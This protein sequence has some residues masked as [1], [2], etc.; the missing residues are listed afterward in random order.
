MAHRFILR[1]SDNSEQ[2][3]LLAGAEMLVGTARDCQIRL[4]YPSVAPYH[5]RV[6]QSA[7]GLALDAL[8][9][10]S[11]VLVNGYLTPVG[12]PVTLTDGSVVQFGDVPLLFR[13]D[14]QPLAQIG[15][16][17]YFAVVHASQALAVT[18]P[19]VVGRDPACDVVISSTQVS[20]RHAQLTPAGGGVFVLED[21]GSTNGTFLNGRRVTRP[22]QVSAGQMIQVALCKLYFDGATLQRFDEDGMVR[23]DAQGITRMIAGG[24]V[25][26]HDITLTVQ[27]RE[28]VAVVGASGAGKSTLLYA[29]S[30]IHPA[31][32]GRVFFNGIDYYRYINLFRASLGYVPQDDIIHRELT[33]EGALRYAA[34]LRMPPDVTA[35]EIEQRI[36]RVLTSLHLTERRSLRVSALSGGQ[37]KRVN[38]GVE[39]MTTPSL[40]FLDEPTS[41]LDPGLEKMMMGELKALAADG[42]TV[43]VVTHAT[44]SIMFCDLVIFMAAG[45]RVAFFGPPQEA[46]E[47]FG[48]D[49]FADIYQAVDQTET[50]EY[51]EAKYKRSVYCDKHVRHRGQALAAVLKQSKEADDQALG[52][53][54]ASKPRVSGWRQLFT[55]TAR[56]CQVMKGDLFNLFYLAMQAPI[57]ALLMVGIFYYK[58]CFEPGSEHVFLGQTVL[59]MLTMSAI[60]FGCGNAAQEICKELPIYRRE[61]MISLKLWP[62]V[63]SKFIVLGLLGA[64]QTIAM[65]AILQWRIFH[66]DLPTTIHMWGFLMMLSLVGCAIGL[67]ISAAASTPDQA[68]TWVPMVLLPQMMLAGIMIPIEKATRAMEIMSHFVAIKWAF[69]GIGR[70]SGL[71]DMAGPPIEGLADKLPP[72][73]EVPTT[74]AA[75]CAELFSRYELSTCWLVLAAFLVAHILIVMILVKLKDRVD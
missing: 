45:G 38:I 71:A 47:H 36:D 3:F 14:Q 6:F 9:A 30:G 13:A 65:V 26:L 15:D 40:L 66:F 42:R 7:Q 57:T 35:P 2:S 11:P 21:L 63:A 44:Q 67:T 16:T 43:F 8:D 51:W 10:A 52:V 48:A 54:E 58:D 32:R 12:R 70:L 64:F 53:L 46:L 4:P 72:G 75:S 5:A 29:L 55:L 73:V 33:V 23:V 31:D 17:R 61:R 34:R 69:A 59:F 62:Y 24:K 20:R 39:L 18:R 22:T 27:P 49:D 50:P 19:I 25:L 41:G 1:L 28:F 74:N 56:Y 60:W 68:T 37:R